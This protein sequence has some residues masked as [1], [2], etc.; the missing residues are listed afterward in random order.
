MGGKIVV[1][2]ENLNSRILLRNYSTANIS[3]H[4]VSIPWNL[5][6]LQMCN[7]VLGYFTWSSNGSM[8]VVAL[9]F[10]ITT[11]W[12]NSIVAQ[13]WK[14]ILDL[15]MPCTHSY[16]IYWVM[17]NIL[18]KVHARSSYQSIGANEIVCCISF[19]D[20]SVKWCI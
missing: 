14:M 4:T 18:A 6:Y 9:S 17:L 3:Q 12:Q 16:R 15:E 1:L 19:H 11:L 13:N 5:N 20:L 2:H 8:A 10:P 7:K